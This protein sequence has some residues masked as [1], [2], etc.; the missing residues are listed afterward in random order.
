MAACLFQVR[1]F[2][3]KLEELV[4]K[5]SYAKDPIKIKK[6]AL[7]QKTDKLLHD[8]LKRSPVYGNTDPPPLQ[9]AI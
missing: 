3:D 7:Q 6:P 9:F 2:L 8:L 4:G 1:D 5:V